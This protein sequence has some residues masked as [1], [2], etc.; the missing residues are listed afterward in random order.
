M[1]RRS[2][3]VLALLLIVTL[4]AGCGFNPQEGEPCEPDPPGKEPGS[5]PPV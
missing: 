2:H 1:L 3:C 5:P 4:V